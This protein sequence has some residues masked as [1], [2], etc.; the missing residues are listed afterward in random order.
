M[1]EQLHDLA[2]D[3]PRHFGPLYWR[4]NT[5]EVAM[6]IAKIRASLPQEVK[7]AANVT[8][9]SEQIVRSAREDADGL[10]KTARDEATGIVADAH[11]QAELILEQARIEQTRLLSE[12]EVLKLAK[13]QAEELKTQSERSATETKRGADDYAYKVLSHLENVLAK[14]NRAIE[15]GKIELDSTRKEAK[16]VG[17]VAIDARDRGRTP[18]NP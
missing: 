7:Q 16:P 12:N 5:E 6:Q 4:V 8:R 11:K 14:A 18:T 13:L 17:L 3:Q 15:S 9:E 1:L 2:V 10:L